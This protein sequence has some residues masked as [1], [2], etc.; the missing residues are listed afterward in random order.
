DCLP[1]LLTSSYSI[2]RPSLANSSQPARP[3]DMDEY[4][5]AA[6]LRLNESIAFRRV[7]PFDLT[8]SYRATFVNCVLW[9]LLNQSILLVL[10]SRA[11]RRRV[12]HTW[13]LRSCLD[14][15]R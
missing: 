3:G 8:G 1:R 11:E 2:S 5:F 15:L 7:K 12:A 13:G 6:V 4:V 9:N 10:P 14:L